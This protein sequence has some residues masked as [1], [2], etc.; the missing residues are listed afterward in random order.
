MTSPSQFRVP[1][2][3][4]LDSNTW[5]GDYAESKAY[6]GA[7][8]TART[9][10]QTDLAVFVGGPGVHPML[11]WHGTWR[12]IATDQNLSVLGAARLFAMLSTIASDALVGCW[13]SKYTY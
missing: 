11:Q 5:L 3:P 10:D 13:D 12:S 8:S 4:A 1:P 9:A 7:I 2:P 6:G